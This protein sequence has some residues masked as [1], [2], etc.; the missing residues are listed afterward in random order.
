MGDKVNFMLLTGSEL[1]MEHRFFLTSRGFLGGPHTYG[2]RA[3]SLAELADGFLS[4]LSFGFSC[5][6][7]FCLTTAFPHTKV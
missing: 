3:T 2:G 1:P 7:A 4:G 5:S 6:L